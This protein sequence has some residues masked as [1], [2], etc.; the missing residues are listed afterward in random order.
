MTN[1]AFTLS[2]FQITAPV[3]AG[4]L[5]C[6]LWAAGPAAAAK[7]YGRA[8]RTAPPPTAQ[9][10]E[11]AQVLTGV[12]LGALPEYSRLVLEF[13]DPVASYTVKRI[14]VDQI[15]LHTPGYTARQGLL[16]LADRLVAG[17]VVTGRDGQLTVRVR[18]RASRFNFRNFQSE[19]QTSII[20]DFRADRL[21]TDAVIA[22]DRPPLNLTIPKVRDVAREVRNTLAMRPQEGSA[23]AVLAQAADHMARGEFESAIQL[24][25]TF[26]TQHSDSPL[27]EKALYLLGDAY[28]ALNPNN[29]GEHFVQATDAYQ[30]ALGLYPTSPMALRGRFML[31]KA[32]MEMDFTSEAIGYYKGVAHDHPDT[33]Y[34]ALAQIYLGELFLK[35]GKRQLAKAAFDKVLALNP[36]GAAFLN[37]YFKLGESY[38]QD[39]LYSQSTEVFK[40]ILN[41]D[42]RYYLT[43]PTI[44]YYLGEGY[45]HLGRMELARAYLYHSLNLRPNQPDADVIMARLG[46][47][48]KDQDNIQEASRI[49]KLTRKLYPDSAG[50]LIA[51]MRLVDFGSLANLY[52]PETVF[53]ELEDGLHA[54]NLEI[55][56]QILETEQKSPLIQLAMFKLALGLLKVDDYPEAIDVFRDI[57]AEYPRGDLAVETRRLLDEAILKQARFLFHTRSYAK[58]VSL[59][60][61]NKKFI[62]RDTWPE[63]RHYLGLAKAELD[64]PSEAVTL[65]EANKGQVPDLE[66]DR[67]KG[68]GYAYLQMG[69]LDKAQQRF[70]AFRDEYPD[71]PLVARTLLDQAQAEIDQDKPKQALNHL[72]AAVQADP[73]MAGRSEVQE[74]LGNLYLDDGQTRKAVAA[75]ENALKNLPRDQADRPGVYLIYS[76]LGQAYAELGQRNQAVAALNNA[77]DQLPDN[78]PPESLYLLADAFQSVDMSDRHKEMLIDLSVADDPFWRDVARQELAAL[79]PDEKITQLLKK[80]EDL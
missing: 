70:Q 69:D 24:L 12:K 34:G 56:R 47:T 41:K 77:Y 43:H 23:E 50:S 59:Y 30:L 51:Q 33:V 66:A 64:M 63:V 22:P 65:L 21:H 19:D 45:F 2:A 49:Y 39:G 10:P 37:S 36:Q 4:L 25:E 20:L 29:L 13:K 16:D 42:G 73:Q 75:Y 76:K 52:S 28:Y 55:Y 8:R 62:D 11:G 74:M 68:L 72:E 6:F 80:A 27:A 17:V 14:D 53:R 79:S 61:K 26:K 18:T 58:L 7:E 44:L 78:P 1:K 5:I 9:A 60:E 3:L 40:T 71:H 35:L 31:A 48:Y 54:A 67:L 38:F 32:F 46:D 57:L 15:E